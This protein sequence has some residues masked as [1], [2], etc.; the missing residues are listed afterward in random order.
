MRRGTVTQRPDR[1]PLVSTSTLPR[2]EQGAPGE[3]WFA[4]GNFLAFATA[5]PIAR[6][7]LGLLCGLKHADVTICILPS[8]K[9]IAERFAGQYHGDTLVGVLP[10]ETMLF[11]GQMVRV[12]PSGKASLYLAHEPG[13]V[14]LNNPEAVR[15]RQNLIGLLS[16]TA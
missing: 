6:L 10:E 11:L 5:Y 4:S 14:C 1:I 13:F 8:D 12:D 9:A 3:Y 16:P 2:L 7:E 15:I